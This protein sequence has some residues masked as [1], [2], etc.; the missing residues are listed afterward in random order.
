MIRMS[1]GF[2]R[3]D[4]VQVPLW[5]QLHLYYY[6]CLNCLI[7]VLTTLQIKVNNIIPL[8]DI[9]VYFIYF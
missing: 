1:N 6:Y 8:N 5:N 3:R 4:W 9:D 2:S 7:P